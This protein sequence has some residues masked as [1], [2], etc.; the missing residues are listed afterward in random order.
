MDL[1]DFDE[2]G[3]L[4]PYDIISSDLPTFKDFFVEK[5]ALSQ[6]RKALF[7]SYLRYLE[8]IRSVIPSNFYQWIDGS[9]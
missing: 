5:I 1:L 3:L 9:V 7:E 2:N 6:T 4:K 8:T